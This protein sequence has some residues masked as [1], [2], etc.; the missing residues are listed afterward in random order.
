MNKFKRL[1]ILGSAAL[2]PLSAFAA[3]NAGLDAINKIPEQ[4]APY[5]YALVAV[6]AGILVFKYIRRLVG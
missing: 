6:G 3:D 1:A 2:L 5:G 4:V